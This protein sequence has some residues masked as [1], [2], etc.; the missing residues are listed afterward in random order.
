M[1][2]VVILAGG[3]GT[4]VASLTGP[5]L[6][7][8]LL[9]VGGRP[10]IDRKIDELQHQGV[11][12]IIVLAGHGGQLLRQHLASGQPSAVRVR[13]II[14]TPTPM[15]TGGALIN[16]REQLPEAF[17]VTYGDTLLN[18]TMAPL[19]EVFGRG[20]SLG[21]LVV[22]RNDDRLQK[23]NTSVENGFVVAYSKDGPVG[24]HRYLDYG[25]L[26]LRRSALDTYDPGVAVDLGRILRDLV[27]R[28]EL[29]ACEVDAEFE[30]IGTPEAWAETDRRYREL[31]PPRSTSTT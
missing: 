9:E 23:S 31:S 11:T 21:M 27:L 25:L 2:P 12:E 16:A 6:P 28:Q 5:E 10:F 3:R 13:C 15:G 8:A 1:L 29:T 19:E 20:S 26:L 17:W 4:R 7:K 22:I 30:D 14:E 18:L 24:T